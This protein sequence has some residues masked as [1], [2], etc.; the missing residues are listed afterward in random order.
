MERS[1]ELLNRYLHAVRIHLP[2]QR[3]D[4]I[5]AEL[6]A[7]LQAQMEDKEAELGHPLTEDEQAAILRRHGHPLLVAARYRPQHSLIGPEIFPFFLFTLERVLPLFIAIYLLVQAAVILF[8]HPD[9]P[10]AQDFNVGDIFN[11][12]LGALFQTAAWIVFAFAALELCFHGNTRNLRDKL[13]GLDWNPRKLPKPGLA[14]NLQGPR[15]PYADAIATA[16]LFVWLL[17]F[18]R[19]PVLMFGPYVAWHLLNIDLPAVWHTFYWIMI[20]F[21]AIQ[22][23]SKIALLLPDVRRYYHVIESVIH[24]VGIAIILVLMRT[25]DYIGEATFGGSPLSPSTIAA[26]NRNIHLGLLV[27]LVITIGKFLWDTAHWLRPN[28][29]PRI[30]G[31]VGAPS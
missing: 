11:G 27:V 13:R 10:I 21:T 26:L 23:A 28:A 31:K 24:L 5:L 1:Y 22:L 15:H 20:G 14:A 6:S 9:T 2:V 18:P 25:R 17:A 29:T 3:Q 30:A 8:G 12:L 19:F 16:I 4:D 7:N